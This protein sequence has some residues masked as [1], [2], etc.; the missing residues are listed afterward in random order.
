M[1]VTEV[2][3]ETK[4]D[5]AF[6][7]ETH[8][9]ANVTG[10]TE[11]DPLSDENLRAAAAIVKKCRDTASIIQDIWAGMNLTKLMKSLNDDKIISMTPVI[12]KLFANS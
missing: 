7:E 11:D 2:T 9:D 1:N 8:G 5:S 3:N 12:A 10:L 6:N 4:V